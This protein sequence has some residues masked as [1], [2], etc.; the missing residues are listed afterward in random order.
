MEKICNMF[1]TSKYEQI[2]NQNKS[3]NWKYWKMERIFK[4]ERK[5]LE[6]F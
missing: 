4:M 6:I 1:K 5:I 2:S 3:S